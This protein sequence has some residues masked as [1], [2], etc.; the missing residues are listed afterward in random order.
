MKA[1]ERA[2]ANVFLDGEEPSDHDCY[3]EYVRG[4][5]EV[6]VLEDAVAIPPRRPPSPS[7]VRGERRSARRKERP[8]GYALREATLAEIENAYGEY[9]SPAPKAVKAKRKKPRAT[10]NSPRK[11]R[12]KARATG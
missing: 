11:R 5:D 3:E 9:L 12:T 10:K 1:S 2:A 7:F 8:D 4:F 6:P